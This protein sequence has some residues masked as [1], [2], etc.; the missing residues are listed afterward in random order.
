M[1]AFA[2]VD[3]LHPARLARRGLALQELDMRDQGGHQK[4]SPLQGY[5]TFLD[6]LHIEAN[7]GDGAM[8]NIR[9]LGPSDDGAHGCAKQ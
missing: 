4:Y 2:G 8:T 1:R 9:T 5:M 3:C 7:G 6:A